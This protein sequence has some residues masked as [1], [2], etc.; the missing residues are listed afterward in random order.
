[1]IRINQINEAFAKLDKNAAVP[2]GHFFLGNK[3]LI[4]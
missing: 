2:A 4:S 1:M 3:N